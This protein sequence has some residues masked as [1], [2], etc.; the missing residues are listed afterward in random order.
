MYHL[1]YVRW[2]FF[3]LVFVDHILKWFQI[4]FKLSNFFKKNFGVDNDRKLY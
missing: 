1:D 2:A 4:K 3:F